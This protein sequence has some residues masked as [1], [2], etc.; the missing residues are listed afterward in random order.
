M[1]H[2]KSG[3]KRSGCLNIETDALGKIFYK[4]AHISPF[5]E[6]HF[7]HN[8]GKQPLHFTLCFIS[9]YVIEVFRAPGVAQK[10]FSKTASTHD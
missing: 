4:F 2:T 8:L 6:G 10:I 1:V 3:L 7:P 5:P 9:N